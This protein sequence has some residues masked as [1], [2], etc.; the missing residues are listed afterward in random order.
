M[1]FFSSV[2]RGLDKFAM[3]TVNSVATNAPQNQGIVVGDIPPG[4]M[5]S[6]GHRPC[7]EHLLPKKREQASTQKEATSQSKVVDSK[8]MNDMF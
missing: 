2:G 4:N 6:K 8:G 1:G 5:P 3:Y 7:P